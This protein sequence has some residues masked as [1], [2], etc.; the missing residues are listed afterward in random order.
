MKGFL[1]VTREWT[2]SND[3]VT[4][5]IDLRIH[6]IFHKGDPGCLYQ[7]NGDP[8]WPPEPPFAEFDYLE[9]ETADAFG[10]NRKWERVE[11]VVDHNEMVDGRDLNA[12]AQ[13]YIND[14]QED[15]I[16]DAAQ[17]DGPDPDDARDQQIE[18]R[19][20]AAMFGD[21]GCDE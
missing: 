7:S 11:D 16:E 19:R 17:G 13:D 4:G 2:D 9:R 18:N 1:T 15:A 5:S 6:Y 10:R 8:G 21:D 14:H 12:W 20:I 3:T